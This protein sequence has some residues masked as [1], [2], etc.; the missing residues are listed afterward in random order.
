MKRGILLAAVVTLL[1]QGCGMIIHGERQDLAIA[2]VPTGATARVGNDECVTPC[3]MRV[4]RNADTIYFTKG[5][6]KDEFY[7]D[8]SL[9]YG[10]T[11]LGN[12]LW[13]FPGVIIDLI[14]G[15]GYTIKPVQV[16]LFEDEE[17]QEQE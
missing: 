5:D 2:T 9:N 10:S 12:V 1:L 7:L 11:F 17:W 4:R 14:G 3:T 6:R 16:K 8:K 13:I 15:G